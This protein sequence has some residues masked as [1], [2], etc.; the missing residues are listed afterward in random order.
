MRNHVA[1]GREGG[2]RWRRGEWSSRAMT[3]GKSGSGHELIAPI[4]PPLCGS[5]FS[6]RTLVAPLNPPL[7]DTRRSRNVSSL[8]ELSSYMFLL[9]GS[10][11]KLPI[12]LSIIVMKCRMHPFLSD[13]ECVDEPMLDFSPFSISAPFLLYFKILSFPHDGNGSLSPPLPSQILE[14]ATIAAPRSFIR[15]TVNTSTFLHHLC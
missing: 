6:K 5:L 10:L 13:A 15:P 8:S 2:G 3:C 12:T 1:G 9:P 14:I 11:F 4:G 7:H